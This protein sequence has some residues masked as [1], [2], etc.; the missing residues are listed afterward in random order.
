MKVPVGHGDRPAP[1]GCFGGLDHPRTPADHLLV[2]RGEGAAHDGADLPG[3]ETRAAEHAEPGRAG[4][5]SS[6]PR[7]G[8]R[9]RPTWPGGQ[10]RRGGGEHRAAVGGGPTRSGA[11]SDSAEAKS[12][13]PEADTGDA[14]VGG[15]SPDHVDETRAP[16]RSVR[17]PGN[18]AGPG[19][20]GRARR[21]GLGVRGFDLGKADPDKPGRPRAREILPPAAAVV[22]RT[23]PAGV[24]AG[25]RG[26]GPAPRG[27]RM[28][29]LVLLGGVDGVF[30]VDEDDV[31]PAGGALL[32]RPA[33]RRERRA[34]YGALTRSPLRTQVRIRSAS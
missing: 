3:V 15:E 30:E 6:P 18:P 10:S 13:S 23:C 7:P 19:A 27:G 20:G 32:K 31:G 2:A 1:A 21:T 24:R 29:G 26:L 17:A 8:R 12:C 5:C 33:G 4:A 28:A 25:A 16:I 11:V 22:D 14:G 9:G 34:R